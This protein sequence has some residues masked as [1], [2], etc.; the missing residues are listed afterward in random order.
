MLKVVWWEDDPRPWRKYPWSEW[1]H[2]PWYHITV[3]IRN[4]HAASMRWVRFTARQSSHLETEELLI[5]AIIYDLI[6]L[7]KHRLTV[8]RQ[9]ASGTLQLCASASR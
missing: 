2:R 4:I 3:I 9:Q 6:I 7:L 8:P 5:Q 1:Q